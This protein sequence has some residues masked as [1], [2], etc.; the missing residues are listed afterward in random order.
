[1][2][3]GEHIQLRAILLVNGDAVAVGPVASLAVGGGSGGDNVLL[4]EGALELL[5]VNATKN[6]STARAGNVAQIQRESAALDELL[7]EQVVE[8]VGVG[9]IPAAQVG[10]DTH[11]TGSGELGVLGNTEGLLV[12]LGGCKF[13]LISV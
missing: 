9:A 10:A 13:A 8:D 12:D 11:D 5:G 6:G 3:L 2:G 4:D 7:S 1:M